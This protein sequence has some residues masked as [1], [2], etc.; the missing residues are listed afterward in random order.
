MS[1]VY[2]NSLST[3]FFDP[4]GEPVSAPEPEPTPEP[5]K[6]R[7]RPPGSK[8]KPKNKPKR[9]IKWFNVWRVAFWASV[10][11]LSVVALYLGVEDTIGR[12][13]ANIVLAVVTPPVALL[14]DRDWRRMRGTSA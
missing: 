10:G 6:R 9:N 8:N 7:G 2:N 3:T 1:S 14:L 5:P 11:V 4:E 13:I 12:G